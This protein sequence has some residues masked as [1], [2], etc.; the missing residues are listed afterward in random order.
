MVGVKE[1]ASVLGCSPKSVYQMVAKDTIPYIRVGVG[2]G[3]LRF[4]VDEVLRALKR[5]TASRS[6][7]NPL[8]RTR[9]RHLR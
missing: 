5:R 4:D 6:A 9:S 3:T 2:R 1:M 8:K 7:L